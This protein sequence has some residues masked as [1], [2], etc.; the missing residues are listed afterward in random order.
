MAPVSW[1]PALAVAGNLQGIYWTILD[2]DTGYIE[3]SAR[4]IAGWGA[5]H[6]MVVS[7]GTG[8]A[9]VFGGGDEGINYGYI[10][11]LDAYLG[12]NFHVYR[13]LKMGFSFGAA[14]PFTDGLGVPGASGGNLSSYGT[15]LIFHTG[16]G[17]QG[18]PF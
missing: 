15:D 9:L 16:F 10:P 6:E 14:V 17:I 7:F 12:F 8:H 4:V 5:P 18:G 13:W 11:S 1:Y 2:R 3:P